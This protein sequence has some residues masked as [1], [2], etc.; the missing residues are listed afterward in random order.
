MGQPIVFVPTRSGPL[1]S[2]GR[3]WNPDARWGLLLPAVVFLYCLVS[4]TPNPRVAL[5]VLAASIA[6][7]AAMMTVGFRLFSFITLVALG[8]LFYYPLPG[9][10]NLLLEVPAV[11]A[12]LWDSAELAMWGCTV[13]CLGL[14]LGALLACLGGSRR[15]RI[16]L[17]AQGTASSFRFNLILFSLLPL[18][19]YTQYLLGIYYHISLTGE[20]AFENSIYNNVLTIIAW[21]GYS[22]I[23]LQ[24][25]RYCQFRKLKDGIYALCMTIIAVLVYFPSGSRTAAIGFL[26]LL[27]ICYLTLENR[28]HMKVAVLTVAILSVFLIVA[29]IGFYRSEI[30][31]GGGSMEEKISTMEDAADMVIEEKVVAFTL[32]V[33]RFSD[34]VA[35]GR[36]IEYTPSIFPFRGGENMED[37]WQ[38]FLPGFL[39]PQVMLANDGARLALTYGV[40]IN[41]MSS[42]PAMIIGDLY[43][44]AGWGAV[45]LGMT[46]VGFLLGWLDRL[47]LNR[48]D[49]FSILLFA[50]LGREIFSIVSMSLLNVFVLFAREV[51]VMSILAFVLF[52][53]VSAENRKRI[54]QHA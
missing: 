30:E 18:V 23:F 34:F 29:V 45:A 25:G 51:I 12:D 26:P 3:W 46:L 49:F 44:R 17:R 19:A 20:Y 16:V 7:M 6:C 10:C 32:I 36:I 42:S 27:L 8:H 39:R 5:A 2:A 21:I 28:I 43:S 52:H 31:A 11:R 35:T 22:G 9:F 41:D 33:R 54:N 14:A 13:G 53:F 15:R 47:L 38:M 40:S 50:L 24:V 1:I 37:W 4:E 48:L